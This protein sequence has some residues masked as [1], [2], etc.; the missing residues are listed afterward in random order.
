[1]LAQF[2]KIVGPDFVLGAARLDADFGTAAIAAVVQK[3]TVALRGLKLAD[4]N[5][6]IVRAPAARRQRNEVAA[7][8]D[9]LVIERDAP[10]ARFWHGIPFLT[11]SS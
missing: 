2:V 6:L 9:D 8:A 1:V 11:F 5:K 3:D 4:R 10:D 7:I